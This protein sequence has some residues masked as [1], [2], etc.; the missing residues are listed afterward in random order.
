MTDKQLIEKVRREVLAWVEAL[1]AK[2]GHV[3]AFREG[4]LRLV[5]T[6]DGVHQEH[7][8]PRL[9]LMIEVDHAGEARNG[10]Q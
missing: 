2:R 4:R 9:E 7:L 3:A 1:H 10:H 8:V 6:R 5:V